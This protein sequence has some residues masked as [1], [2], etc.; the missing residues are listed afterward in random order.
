MSDLR[1][2]R[3]GTDKLVLKHW[4]PVCF[5]CV[6]DLAAKSRKKTIEEIA[7]MFDGLGIQC[8][9]PEIAAVIVRRMA[10]P[11]RD[12]REGIVK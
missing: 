4:A 9:S 10:M 1:C 12:A 8:L 5:G 6:E 11:K 2:Y 3:C 7:M